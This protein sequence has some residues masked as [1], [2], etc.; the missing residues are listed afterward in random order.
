MKLFPVVVLSSVFFLTGASVFAADAAVE[1]Q[2]G[3]VE[4]WIEYYEKERARYNEPVSAPE[5]A[6]ETEERT[7]PSADTASQAPTGVPSG[8]E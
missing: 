2:E 6:P 3:D 4:H 1:A 5:T 8:Q 7:A